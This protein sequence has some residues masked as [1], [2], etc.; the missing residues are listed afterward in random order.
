MLQI[1]AREDK[2]INIGR[3]GENS[4]RVVHFDITNW[5]ETY[6]EGDVLLVVKR[7]GDLHPYSVSVAKESNQVS[8]VIS[9]V[10]VD[11]PGYGECE[12]IYIIDNKVAKSTLYQTYTEDSLSDPV[13]VPDSPNTYASTNMK[14]GNLD[15]LST[16]D[17][18]SLV[19]AINEIKNIMDN[20]ILVMKP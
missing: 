15:E 11:S 4:A 13:H 1:N 2:C 8:W 3:R 14:I 12:L 10:D 16:E 5:I 19:R 7:Y 6:G 18:T 17:K 20:I 9:S